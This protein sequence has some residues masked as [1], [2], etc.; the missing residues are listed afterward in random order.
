M[1]AVGLQKELVGA[2]GE[3]NLYALHP[4][5]RLFLAPKTEDGLYRQIAAALATG[6]QLVID[7]ATGLRPSLK[8]LPVSVA[9]RITW[10]TD[11]D[12]DGPFASALV[13]GDADR[14]CAINKKIAALDGPLVLVQTATTDEIRRDIETNCLNWLV[15]EVSPRSTTAAAS[16][17]CEL[18]DD[19]LSRWSL[20]SSMRATRSLRVRAPGGC[21]R[22][23]NFL[24]LGWPKQRL[25]AAG[26]AFSFGVDVHGM[27]DLVFRSKA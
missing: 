9:D 10:S 1:P 19:W 11:W 4:R 27:I 21:L 16:G 26:G 5:G 17:E 23:P 14:A 24:P 20:G 22:C 3:R 6:N 2:V 8:G 18:D 12:K 25:R 7:V 15:E 13:E